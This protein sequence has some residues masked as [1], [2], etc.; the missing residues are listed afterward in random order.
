MPTMWKRGSVV[1][2]VLA[3][4]AAPAAA[5]QTQDLAAFSQTLES[6]TQ[7]VGPA[8]RRQF[9]RQVEG[10]RIEGRQ[11]GGQQSGQQKP[12][13]EQGGQHQGAAGGSGGS[14]HGRRMR[15]SIQP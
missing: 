11:P 3:L 5:Q 10:E 1:T 15:G 4:V 9:S 13:T 14:P 2:L 12:H 7:R 6:L 8:G